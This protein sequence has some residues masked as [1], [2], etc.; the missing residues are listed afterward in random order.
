LTGYVLRRLIQAILVLWVIW[1]VIFVLYFVVPHDPARLLMGYRAP[2]RLVE[3]L[4]VALG[5]ERPVWDQ[6][7]DY[8]IRIF[9]GNLGQSFVAGAPVS[10]IVAADIPVDV[11]LGLPAAAMWILLGLSVGILA[12]RRPGSIRA[13]S[14]MIFIFSIVSTPTFILGGILLF[15]SDEILAPHGV[16]M[17]PFPGTW[18]PLH[19][20]PGSWADHMVLPWI[21]L[22]LIS[23]AAYARLSRSSLSE[24]L[25]EDYVRTARAKGLSERRVLY[26]HVL[27][28]A[29]APLVSQF[30]IDLAA[31]LTGAVVVEVVFDLPGLGLQLIKAV[32]TEDL[33]TIQGIALLGSAFVVGA[34]LLV[35]LVYA[36]IDPKVRLGTSVGSSARAG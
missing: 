3:K 29:A 5:L 2:E 11:E 1:T 18:V 33:P 21:T 20:D 25:Q 13:R 15:I 35:D 36:V 24:V 30:G 14:A 7:V 28:A 9:H 19:D 6:Y 4:R 17:F 34:N 12:V 10:S 22:A 32:R 26:L 23:S 27:R 8:L 16:H 31:V